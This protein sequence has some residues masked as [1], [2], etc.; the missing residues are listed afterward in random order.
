MSIFQ[1]FLMRIRTHGHFFK[2]F[3]F[4]CVYSGISTA[5]AQYSFPNSIYLQ[6]NKFLYTWMA[7]APLRFSCHFE[8]IKIVVSTSITISFLWMLGVD[9]VEQACYTNFLFFFFFCFQSSC[10]SK[11]EINTTKMEPSCCVMFFP[12]MMR[13]NIYIYLN[14]HM[15][16]MVRY[17]YYYI[18]KLMERKKN[19][20]NRK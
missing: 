16:K 5:R 17:T 6:W 7:H 8:R 20:T 9:N 10:R 13:T 2:F 18:F 12:F 19:A 11:C 4:F 15:W 1:F 3:F 14:M